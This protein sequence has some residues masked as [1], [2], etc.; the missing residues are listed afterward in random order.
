MVGR[1][2]A[3]GWGGRGLGFSTLP[4]ALRGVCGGVQGD[5]G[6]AGIPPEAH[7]HSAEAK[8]PPLTLAI[9]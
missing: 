7:I 4:F 8:P 6:K 1:G 5:R 3:D 9:Q 2:Q